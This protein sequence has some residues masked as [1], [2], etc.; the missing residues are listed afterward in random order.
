MN[1]GRIYYVYQHVTPDGMYYF[2]V[3]NNIKRRW[4]KSNYKITSLCPYIEKWGWENIRHDILLRELTYEE[5]RKTENMLIE[6]A[7]EDGCCINE[8]KS[9]LWS[10]DKE[11]VIEHR[12]EFHNKNKERLNEKCRKYYNSNIEKER[13]RCR[14]YK[15]KNKER[16]KEYREA[17]KERIKERQRLYYEEN[18]ERLLKKDSDYYSKNKE[19]VLDRQRKSYYD[20]I[21]E[22]RKYNREKARRLRAKKKQEKQLKDFGYIPLF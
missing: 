15:N 18:K 4:Q 6:T 7:T 13:E 17:N 9:G 22:K 20:N 21:E 11:M 8:R 1:K 5:S 19:K 12:K 14:E 2:G 3:T 10:L 16:I